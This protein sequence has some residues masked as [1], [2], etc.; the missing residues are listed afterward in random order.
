M[1]SKNNHSHDGSHCAVCDSI[2]SMTDAVKELNAKLRSLN[3]RAQ[4]KAIR[5]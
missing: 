4:R 5:Y 1:K 2:D 3:Q